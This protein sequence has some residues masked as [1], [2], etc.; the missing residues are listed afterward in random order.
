MFKV[1]IIEYKDG[2]PGKSIL[3]RE[4]DT[5]QHADNFIESFNSKNTFRNTPSYYTKAEMCPPEESNEI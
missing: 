4:F 2:S 1:N 5:E 3:D